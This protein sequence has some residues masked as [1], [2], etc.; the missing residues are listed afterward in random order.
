MVTPFMTV[1]VIAILLINISIYV[2]ILAGWIII[3]RKSPSTLAK[4][5]LIGWV[6]VGIG[7]ILSYADIIAGSYIRNIATMSGLIICS[8]VFLRLAQKGNLSIDGR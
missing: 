2:M 6:L 4:L 7:L 3:M 5:G 1:I 8:F